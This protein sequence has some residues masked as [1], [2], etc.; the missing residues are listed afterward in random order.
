MVACPA[1]NPIAEKNINVATAVTISGTI[2]GRLNKGKESNLPRNLP[3]RSIAIDAHVAITVETVAAPIAMVSE[4]K[5]AC[6]NFPASKPKKTSRYQRSDTLSKRVTEM[7]SLNEYTITI[8]S[9]AYNRNMHSN[10]RAIKP[11][12]CRKFVR[13]DI[14]VTCVRAIA[15]MRNK[16]ALPK[17]EITVTWTPPRQKAN[18]RCCP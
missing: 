12:K 7:L 9:G 8:I 18:Y 13:R 16:S 10:P 3:A 1:A 17:P 5:V 14:L 11:G 15:I 4:L 2:N 6:R